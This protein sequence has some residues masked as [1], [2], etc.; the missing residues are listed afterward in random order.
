MPKMLTI[1]I[2]DDVAEDVTQIAAERGV[3]VNRLTLDLYRALIDPD[4]AVSPRDSLRERLKRAGL[5]VVGADP[6]ARRPD[7]DALTRG[8]R[9]LAAG[10]P[11]SDYVSDQ[12][13]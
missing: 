10:A 5:V 3:S 8:Q 2:P 11:L 9:A 6:S 7:G 13:G 4:T 1:R 12:R